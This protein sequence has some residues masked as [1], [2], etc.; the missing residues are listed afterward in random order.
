[1][2]KSRDKKSPYFFLA[3]AILYLG[4]WIYY[5]IAKNF[6]LSFV[7]TEETHGTNLHF[8]GLSNYRR[9]LTDDLFYRALFHNIA[10]VLLS[11]LVP[12]AIYFIAPYLN[13]YICNGAV[14]VPVAGSDPDMDRDALAVI[15]R[16]FPDRQIIDITMRASFMQGGAV[17]CLT[18]QVP[19]V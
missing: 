15:S 11:I 18:Q 14:I 2:S 6:Y 3:P 19:A 17:H 4:I 12:V 16:E 8:V 1:M 5:P 7:G 9:L 13:F 10:W